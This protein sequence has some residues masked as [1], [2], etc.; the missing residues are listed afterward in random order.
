MSEKEREIARSILE[1][2]G[3]V[4]NIDTLQHCMTRIRLTLHDP[5]RVNEDEI[6][7]IPG[8]AGIVH[9]SNQLQ[10]ILGPGTAAQVAREI[11]EETGLQLGEVRDPEAEKQDRSRG[12]VQRFLRRLANIFVP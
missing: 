8:V 12:P 2:V 1:K 5:D 3:G 7:A 6:R 11:A 4:T 9:S 10:I